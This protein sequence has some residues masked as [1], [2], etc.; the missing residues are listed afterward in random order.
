[1]I[2]IQWFAAQRGSSACGPLNTVPLPQC[3]YID[4]SSRAFCPSLPQPIPCAHVVRE[5]TNL[6][7]GAN[8]PCRDH[9]ILLPPSRCRD[10]TSRLRA[11]RRPGNHLGDHGTRNEFLRNEPRAI[12]GSLHDSSCVRRDGN[13]DVAQEHRVGGARRYQGHDRLEVTK[14]QS[15]RWAFRHDNL[16]LSFRSDRTLTFCRINYVQTL[17][18]HAGCV[19]RQ[20][21]A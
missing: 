5:A 2:A 16:A 20:E 10:D 1:M 9:G 17:I 21:A 12:C 6:L 4:E 18:E 14:C 3:Q 19:R 7:Q 8:G 15:A 11:V 13:K